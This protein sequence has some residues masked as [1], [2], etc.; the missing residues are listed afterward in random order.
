V[1]AP[2]PLIV[3][4]G[5]PASGKTYVANMLA[6]TL[7][8]PLIAK[9]AIK[10]VLYDQLGMDDTAWSRRLGK[11]TFALMYQA[12]EAQLRARRPAIIEANFAV[13]EARDNFR[14]LEDRYSVRFLEI[15]CTANREALLARYA[16]RAASR[17]AGH[18]DERRLP[19]VE[20][21][22]ASARHAELRLGGGLIVVDT[23]SFADVDVSALVETARAHVADI[24]DLSS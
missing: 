15:H 8:V 12:L 3:V 24:A 1:E 9:D 16:G 17:H 14:A 4:S 21:A 22:I 10:E 7:G 5:P 6:E 2:T 13:E 20:S 23:T 19:E 11:A 18:A